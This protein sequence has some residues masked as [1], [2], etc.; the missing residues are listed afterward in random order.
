MHLKR[1]KSFLKKN[2]AEIRALK[3]HPLSEDQGYEA[4]KCNDKKKT[5]KNTCSSCLKNISKENELTMQGCS[6]QPLCKRFYC[7]AC[8]LDMGDFDWCPYCT[9]CCSCGVF[10]GQEWEG[11]YQCGGFCRGWL[12]LSCGS[13]KVCTQ[14]TVAICRI[15]SSSSSGSSSG[16]SRSSSKNRSSSCL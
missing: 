11:S 12:C 8:Y 1:K 16:S 9:N 15:N 10:Q 7:G 13:K 2:S 3:L 6:N 5:G 4:Y 14:C